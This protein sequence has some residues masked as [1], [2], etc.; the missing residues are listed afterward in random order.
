MAK[1]S[2]AA[3]AAGIRQAKQVFQRTGWTQSEFAMEV[4][5]ATRQPIWKFFSGRPVERA[6]FIDICFSLNLEWEEI[7]G[8]GKYA[9]AQHAAETAEA[10]CEPVLGSL[11]CLE[12]VRTHLQEQDQGQLQWMPSSLDLVHPLPLEAAYVPQQLWT[13]PRHLRQFEPSPAW[14]RIDLTKKVQQQPKLIL[15][16]Q[17]GSGKTTALRALR[18]FCLRRTVFADKVPLLLQLSGEDFHT[19]VEQQWHRNGL[20]P[21]QLAALLQSGNLLLLVDGFD[22]LETTERCLMR[23]DLEQWSQTYPRN[24]IVVSCRPNCD[25]AQ[26]YDFAIAELATLDSSQVAVYAQRWFT[27]VEAT[28]QQS[29]DRLASLG[30]SAW[31]T[32]PDRRPFGT[33]L[34]QSRQFLAAWQQLNWPQIGVTPLILHSIAVL[35]RKQQQWANSPG[36][37][38]QTLLDLLL[39]RWERVSGQEHH[40]SESPQE[41]LDALAHIAMSQ[42]TLPHAPYSVAQLAQARRA[43]LNPAMGIGAEWVSSQRILRRLCRDYGLLTEVGPEQYQMP[44]EILQVYLCALQFSMRPEPDAALPALTQTLQALPFDLSLS[45]LAMLL[46]LAANPSVITQALL[47]HWQ[48]EL[49]LGATPK[50]AALQQWLHR[51]AECCPEINPDF[52]QAFYYCL[53]QTEGTELLC[54]QILSYPVPLPE[55]LAQD[56]W[57]QQGLNQLLQLQRCG[58][59]AQFTASKDSFERGNAQELLALFPDLNQRDDPSALDHPSPQKSEHW[60]AWWDSQGSLFCQTIQDVC[61]ATYDLRPAGTRSDGKMGSVSAGDRALLLL[62]L[63]LVQTPTVFQQVLLPVVSSLVGYYP[64]RAQQGEVE[65]PAPW[66]ARTSKF[67]AA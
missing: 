30:S 46:S 65:S 52:A 1:R 54:Q 13:T 10:S 28:E 15:Q 37:I 38:A 8:V 34:D 56:L 22:Q 41:L 66:A 36:A 5:L 45:W 32:P 7:A 33:A 17:I 24:A 31:T 53:T 47:H 16:G 64:L 62:I 44:H 12:S 57:I 61:Q 2:I 50:L 63:A 48:R 18:Q 51:K 40:A 9:L 19:Q 21:E 26:F 27:A 25:E 29:A 55:P 60:Q 39:F 42:I 14:E 58:Q 59:E 67:I 3:T 43:A 35:F 6:V 23:A 20:Q 4:G 11:S 49:E